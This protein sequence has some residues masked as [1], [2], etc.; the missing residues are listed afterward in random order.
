MLSSVNLGRLRLDTVLHSL[1]VLEAIGILTQAPGHD[2]TE[3]LLSDNVLEL[4]GNEVGGVPGPE[5]VVLLVEV[6]LTAELL[7]GL[8]VLFG[9]APRFGDGDALASAIVGE[10]ASLTE[11]IT[12]TTK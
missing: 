2:T 3:L 12:G 10:T 1:E 5:E 11:V 6:V 4:A 9:L 7:V 8:A